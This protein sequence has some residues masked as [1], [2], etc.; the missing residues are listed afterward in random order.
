M[1]W[2]GMDMTFQEVSGMDIEA[3]SVEYRAANSLVFAAI[4]MPGLKKYGRVTL[5]KGVVIS[6]QKFWDW[7]NAIKLNTA[8]RNTVIISLRDEGGKPTMAWRLTNAYPT[9]ITG[10][11][12]KSTGNEVAVESIE[13]V[14][15]GIL[16]ANA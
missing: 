13:I 8:K 1:Q 6:D 9:K 12:L 4:K 5:K 14:H 3:K 2:D 15:E 7:L 11:D 10:T 16:V